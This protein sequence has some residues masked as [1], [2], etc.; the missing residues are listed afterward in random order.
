M[1]SKFHDTD[2]GYIVAVN[3]KWYREYHIRFLA[4]TR[5]WIVKE[6]DVFGNMLGAQVIGGYEW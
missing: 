5:R 3:N 2:R 6:Y 4:Y 1:K